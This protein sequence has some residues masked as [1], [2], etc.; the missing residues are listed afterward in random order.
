MY[1]IWASTGYAEFTISS[2][3]TI[4][5]KC[6]GTSDG[7]VYRQ[8]AVLILATASTLTYS[9]MNPTACS[10]QEQDD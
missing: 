1:L 9:H 8:N 4:L 6:I 10:L 3:A 5:A 2:G 7:G